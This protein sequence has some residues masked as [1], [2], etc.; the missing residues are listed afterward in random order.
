MSQES[1]LFICIDNEYYGSRIAVDNYVFRIG[2]ADDH[3]YKCCNEKC[4]CKA[5]VNVSLDNKIL[6]G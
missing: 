3:K 6:I 2:Y 5:K 1:R 4:H